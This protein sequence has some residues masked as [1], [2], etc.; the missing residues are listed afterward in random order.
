MLGNKDEFLSALQKNI[1]TVIRQSAADIDK[2]LEELQKEL[3]R[4]ANSKSDYHAIADE[5]YRLRELKQQSE[6]EGVQRDE[7]IN[8]ITQLHDFINAQPT[9]ITEFD[10]TLV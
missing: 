7:Q 8:R 2:R 5:I 3:L 6:V 9:E 4:L 10:E 1:T